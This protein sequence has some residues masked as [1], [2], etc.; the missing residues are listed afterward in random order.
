MEVR[1]GVR[2]I[3]VPP[4]KARA[5]AALVKGKHVH[6]ALA[7]LKFTPNATA[8][9]LVKLVK[10]AVANAENNN[11]LDGDALK[12]QRVI[13]DQGPSYKRTQPRSMGRA[14]RILKRT[15]HIAVILTEAE[16]RP[17]RGRKKAESETRRGFLS[18]RRSAKTADETA[19]KKRRRKEERAVE[20][21]KPVEEQAGDTSAE[22][23][24]EEV[25]E[26]AAAEVKASEEEAASVEG[27]T[28]DTAQG[29]SK[30][31]K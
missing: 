17:T 11:H 16:A 12:V 4:R 13:V 22:T 14:Y 30:G 21:E 15:S 6:D 2:F 24:L 31:G 20:P 19:E 1:A 18:K 3:R 5:V 8:K 28:E 7:I 23:E 10:S 29:E 27:D 26:Q 25:T 9:I